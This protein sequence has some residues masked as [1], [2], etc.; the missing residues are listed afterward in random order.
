MIPR[1]ICITPLWFILFSQVLIL[2]YLAVEVLKM[3]RRR[4][5][6]RI[7][8]KPHDYE[9]FLRALSS[10]IICP[11]DSMSLVLL[12]WLD[13]KSTNLILPLP[14]EHLFM[15]RIYFTWIYMRITSHQNY[16]ETQCN[17]SEYGSPHR[18]A[19]RF[20]VPRS[21][22]TNRDARFLCGLDTIPLLDDLKVA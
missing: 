15:I 18:I 1:R 21:M 9:Y 14:K 13:A 19:C 10:L 20:S 6:M 11:W 2:R 5:T 4:N 8:N 7:N 17:E 22:T 3:Y 16:D 12:R